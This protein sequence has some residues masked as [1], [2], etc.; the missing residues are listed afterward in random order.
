MAYKHDDK[1]S[2]QLVRS[3]DWNTMGHAIQDL[4]GSKVD[5]AGDTIKGDLS[6]TGKVSAD[7]GQ[8]TSSLQVT[9][10]ASLGGGLTVGGGLT[11][12][13]I[14]ATGPVQA[15]NSDLYFTNTAH[16]HT[17]FG[18]TEAYAAIENSRNYDALMILGRAHTGPPLKRTVRLWDY[19]HVHGVFEADN[20]FGGADFRIFA[21]QTPMG[22]T[23][24][25]AYGPTGVVVTVDTS[26]AGFGRTPL[27]IVSLHGNSS[28]W[29]TTGG[30]SVYGPSATGF[31]I[32]LRWADGSPL[33]PATANANGW[34]IQWIGIQI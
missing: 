12:G 22:S 10:A 1:S 13:A 5:R 11:A 8:F 29:S 15:A 21:G 27:Y 23:A 30:T 24:W 25:Q 7:S 3:A 9:G 17:G 26:A 6:V 34:H 19:L 16:D 32:Y 28:H 20:V 2:G 33:V 31:V 18:N 4:D 14:Q